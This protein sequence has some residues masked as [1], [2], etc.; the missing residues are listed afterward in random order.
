[1]SFLDKLSN[2]VSDTAKNLGKKSTDLMEVSKL[3]AS[4][5]KREEEII[6]LLEEM[7]Q[8]VYSRLKRLNYVSREELEPLVSTLEKLE[9]ELKNLEKL[10]LDIK[11]VK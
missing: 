9:A 2:S 11:Q 6:N 5:R 1:M 7:G 10:I 3:K 4:I 8:Y